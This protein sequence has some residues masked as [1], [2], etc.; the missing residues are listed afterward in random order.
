[1]Y[2]AKE[3]PGHYNEKRVKVPFPGALHLLTCSV[4][5]GVS[6]QFDIYYVHSS[7]TC[8]ISF[9]FLDIFLYQYI[10]SLHCF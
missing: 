4:C 5:V 1:M 7:L 10:K 6:P 2:M 9:I 3:N 8:F